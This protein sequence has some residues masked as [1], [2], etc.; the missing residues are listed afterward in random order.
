MSTKTHTKGPWKLHCYKTRGTIAE[1]GNTPWDYASQ[2][3]STE[4]G[5]I[6]GQA[7][8][9]KGAVGGYPEVSDFDE[10]MANARLIAE[11]PAILDMLIEAVEYIDKNEDRTNP[12]VD[13]L[14]K[15]LGRISGEE[16]HE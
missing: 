6:V 4:D 3:I 13:R 2:Y 7:T 11:S 8:M 9:T 16:I 5:V 1:A 10:M 14:D 12:F 15:L